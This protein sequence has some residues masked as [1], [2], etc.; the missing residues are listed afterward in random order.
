MVRPLQG[1]LLHIEQGSESGT[2]SWFHNPNSQVSAHF[3]NPKSGGLDQWVDTN[4]AAWAEAAGNSKWISIENEG[5]SGDALTD[6]QVANAALLLA[7]LNLTENIPMQLADAT[8]DFGLGYHSMGGVPW[9]NHPDCPGA[10]IIAQ[11]ATIV[12]QAQALVIGPTITGLSAMSGSA[13]DTIVIA[14]SGFTFA[15]SVGFGGTSVP[16]MVVTGDTQITVTV[17]PGSDTVDVE[18]ITLVGTSSPTSAGQFT[19]V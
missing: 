18:V 10:P 7:W 2:D 5:N 1:L 3:G 12:A 8:T 16:S 9:G 17:P 6:N 15:T 13:G 19:Y 11:R 14:G 4:D